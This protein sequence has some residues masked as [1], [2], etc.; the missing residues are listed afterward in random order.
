MIDYKCQDCIGMREH[1]CYCQNRGALKPGG[2]FPEE[3]DDPKTCDHD[4][5]PDTDE[6]YVCYKCGSRYS[7]YDDRVG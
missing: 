1:G 7:I 3:L 4:W 6:G 2:P 5:E